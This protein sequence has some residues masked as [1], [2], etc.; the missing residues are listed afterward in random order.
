MSEVPTE[1]FEPIPRLSKKDL[2]AGGPPSVE[3]A[4]FLVDYYYQLQNVRIRAAHQTR[5]SGEAEEPSALVNW[6]FQAS[7][8]AERTIVRSL[9]LL[10]M[11]NEVGR[12]SRSVLGIGPVLAAGL[13]AHIKIERAPTAGHIWRFAGLDS[14][15]TWPSTE[16]AGAYIKSRTEPLEEIIPLAAQKFGRDVTT[17][18]RFATTDNK[19]KAIK[20]TPSSLA[21]AIARRPWNAQLK[22]LCWKIGESFVYVSGNEDAFYGRV[23]AERKL[24]EEQRNESGAL[25]EQA[26]ASLAAKRFG[27]DTVARKCYEQGRLPPARI[28]LRAERYAVKLFLSHWHEVAYRERFGQDPPAP[29]PITRLGHAHKIEVPTA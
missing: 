22:T 11:S 27:E 24:L 28:H 8:I 19:K 18:K 16:S 13:I 2:I 4:R 14:T 3:E 1:Q 5:K 15:V 9:D 26:T 17:L 6:L 23:Y 20:L 29:Y 21:R 7:M 10:S 25:A 12:W